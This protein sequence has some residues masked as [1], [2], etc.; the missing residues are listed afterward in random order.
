[1]E[2]ATGIK[3]H[4]YTIS[5]Y[6]DWQVVHFKLPFDTFPTYQKQLITKVI[7]YDPDR[8][9]RKLSNSLL[10]TEEIEKHAELIF[11]NGEYKKTPEGMLFYQ[12]RGAI[13][14]FEK[15][16]IT[17]RMSHG[18][19]QK[20]RQG[21]VLRDFQIYGYDYDKENEKL[22][23]NEQEAKI[24]KLIFELFTNE[25]SRFKGING[26]AKYLTELGVPTK[27][28]AKQWHRQVVSQILMNEVYT[29]RFFQ[30]KWNTEGMLA[31]KFAKSE[32]EKVRMS[33]RPKEEWIEIECPAI[34]SKETF[35]LAQRKLETSRRRWAG[36]NK[37]TY[38]L[39]GLLRC[40]N[41]GNTMTGRRSKKWGKY[42]YEY[43]D[44]K[45][46][47]GARHK[48][49]GLH[50]KCEELDNIVWEAFKQSLFERKERNLNADDAIEE[51]VS[52]EQVEL[53]RVESELHRIKKGK[54]RLINA[55]TELDE[56]DEIKSKLTE[57][58]EREVELLKRQQ[59]LQQALQNDTNNEVSN[60]ILNE[61]T[62][63]LE[64]QDAFTL[65]QKR[66]ILRLC[67]REIYV[68]REEKPIE[69]Y[70]I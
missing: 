35:D 26:I 33:L 17:E 15:A 46:T 51:S 43:T 32:E 42:V 2:K 3:N 58:K 34:I 25:D 50:I 41:C 44:L 19:R 59:E 31:N 22:V 48:G 69:I 6:S 30:N 66:E 70:T 67:V 29:G 52:L 8:L 18:R 63:L 10:I 9:S 21:K 60:N 38:L 23:I 14:E 61:V 40:G 64:R 1:M 16:K 65:E 5:K 47:A 39:S 49:C 54:E 12:L 36:T 20:A 53:Q 28:G 62:E 55:L 57:L 24:V 56:I 11:V 7:C 45:N 37:H 4:Y 13:A 68:Y 27:R